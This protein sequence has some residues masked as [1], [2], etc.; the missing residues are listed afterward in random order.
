MSDKIAE[1][2]SALLDNEATELDVR[3]LTKHMSDE[4]LDTWRRLCSVKQGLH[5]EDMT[6]AS[7]NLLEG[8]RAGIAD[9]EIVV[10][11]S[12]SGL[13][14]WVGG[15]GVAAAVAMAVVGIGI[16]NDQFTNGDAQ[17]VENDQPKVET[18]EKPQSSDDSG[19][20]LAASDM[21][22]EQYKA[23]QDKL[24]SYMQHHAENSTEDRVGD[25]MP[26]ARVVSF[27]VEEKNK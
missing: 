2:L 4:D 19:T 6:F 20:R 9:E 27:E 1:S 16:Q 17:F 8:V 24:R 22:P 12:R 11:Q 10:K 18:S 21:S 14:Q 3:R 5:N 25:V 26:Y 7:V 15:F 23:L 13:K